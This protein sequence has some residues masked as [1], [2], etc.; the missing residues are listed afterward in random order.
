MSAV[1]GSHHT[2]PTQR[3]DRIRSAR[4]FDLNVIGGSL[5]LTPTEFQSS[6]DSRIS[7]CAIT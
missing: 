7:P 2:E 5:M 3:S 1:S 4:G 6:V